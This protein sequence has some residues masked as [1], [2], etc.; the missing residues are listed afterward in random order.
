MTTSGHC[1]SKRAIRLRSALS[2]GLRAFGLALLVNVSGAASPETMPRPPQPMI[3]I[4]HISLAVRDLEG[5]ADT[6][7]HLGFAVTTYPKTR[8]ASIRSA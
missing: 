4:D 8:S 6:Y 3:G 5:A 2:G 1:H 7:R